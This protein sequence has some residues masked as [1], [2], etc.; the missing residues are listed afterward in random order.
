MNKLTFNDLLPYN[1]YEKLHNKFLKEVIAEKKVR[2]F[3]ISDKMSGLFENKLTVF[4]QVQEMIRAEKITDEN[5]IKE[6]LYVY[7]DL[8][9]E[10]DELSMTLFIEIP[11]Q[12][13][14]RL[15][16]KT[17]VGIEESVELAFE[18]EVVKS[19]EPGEDEPNDDESYTQS[20]HY[21]HFHFNDNQ[22]AAFLGTNKV[23]L[24]VNHP[25]Y[26]TE[27]DLSSE[28]LKELQKQLG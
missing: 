23:T 14:L 13:E 2:R 20:I 6:M 24:K 16:N 26:Q 9:P 15:F 18:N 3:D 7:N 8:L 10:P 21:L 12:E 4:Y 11:N 17:V 25:N 5:Y 19:Y 27:I 22:K 28:L 1:E